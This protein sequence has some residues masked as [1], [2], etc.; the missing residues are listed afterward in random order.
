MGTVNSDFLPNT[1]GQ[2][3]GSPSQQWDVFAKDIVAQTVSVSGVTGTGALV[4]VP[5]SPTPTFDCSQGSIFYLKLTGNVT[6]SGVIHAGPGLVM[7]LILQQDAV[8][9]HTFAWPGG[10]VNPPA[11]LSG[12]NQVTEAIFAFW[13]ATNA[14]TAAFV[15]PAVPV[16][17]AFNLGGV[18]PKSVVSHQFLTGLGDGTGDFSAAQPSYSDIASGP[19]T[20]TTVTLTNASASVANSTNGGN[21]ALTAA[22]GTGVNGGT[23]ILTGGNSTSAAVGGSVTLVPGTGTSTQ[24]ACVLNGT[25]TLAKTVTSYNGNTLV[26][27][28]VGSI[29]AATDLTA[30]GAA[31][32]AT[33]IIASCPST[34]LYR[35][36]YVATVTRAAT[37]SCVLGGAAGFQLKFTNASDS[38]VKTSN[39]TTVVSSAVNATGT[40]ISGSLSAR[41]S[42]GTALQFLMDYTSVGGTTM[43]YDLS[44]YAEI[45]G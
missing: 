22:A 44:V 25:V 40:T 20:A 18:H 3:L 41:C 34:A 6:S 36:T 4:P 30:Q 38:V 32:S 31:I 29:F 33:N 42:S 14:A 26:R 15:V 37:T 13:T 19:I 24:G 5:F 1:T 2:N 9:S 16:P 21:L 8:G 23:I 39:P 11:L 35:V 7:T 12:A 28:G 10:L 27:G 45:L 17:T 43:Q